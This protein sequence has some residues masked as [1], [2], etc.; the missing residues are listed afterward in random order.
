[1]A[2]AGEKGSIKSPELQDLDRELGGLLTELVELETF[3]GKAVRARL[4][5]MAADQ[6]L[7]ESHKALTAHTFQPDGADKESAEEVTR[8]V[9]HD[10]LPES[11]VCGMQG[12][13]TPLCATNSAGR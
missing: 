10:P 7:D 6:C 9:M 8:P 12:Q 2:V 1:M 11:I 3:T 4:A 13:P 5:C